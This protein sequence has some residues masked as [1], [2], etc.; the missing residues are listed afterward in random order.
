MK[1]LSLLSL[2][3]APAIAHISQG[4]TQHGLI[5]YGIRMYDPPCAFAC[6]DV[7]TGWMLH[8]GDAGTGGQ[9]HHADMEMETPSPLC[10]ATNDPFLQTLAWC[11][12]THCQSETMSKL[13]GWWEHYLVGRQP[14]QP[15]PKI[16]YQRALANVDEP[17][18]TIISE[19]DYLNTTSLVDEDSWLAKLN[20]DGGY[21]ITEKRSNTYG[22]VLLISCSVIPTVFSLFRFLPLPQSF[23]SK[24]Y[25]YFIDPPA[26][27]HSH[28][29][30]VFG[31]GIVPTR[32]QALFIAYIWIINILLSA[33]GYHIT[34]PNSWYGHKPE[35]VTAYFGNRVGVLSFANLGLTVLYSSRNNILLYLTNWSHSTFLLVH[36]W[37]AFICTLQ[38]C[39]H[40]AVWLQIYLAQG[41]EAHA[42]Q[43][44]L[45]YWIW[46]IVATMALVILLPLSILPIRQKMYELFLASHVVIAILSMIG[47][48]LHIYYRFTWQ[49]GYETWVY[50]A[51]VIWGFDRFFARP[52][53]VLR[54]G[55]KRAYVTV[56][57]EDYLKVDIPGVQASG[58]A[59]LYFPGL[60][61]RV[62]E[63]HPFSVAAVSGQGLS[64]ALSFER[65]GSKSDAPSEELDKEGNVVKSHNIVQPT[66]GAGIT[67]FVRRHGG[68][69][70]QLERVASST[71]G[72]LVL[73]ESSYGPEQMS[74]IPSPVAKP[75]LEYPNVIFFAGGVGITAVLPLL[76][77][78]NSL[79]S[80]LGKAKL[81]WGVRTES[82]VESVEKMLGQQGTR[83][84]GQSN[85]ANIEVNVSVGERFDVRRV[86][87]TELN[88]STGGTT[89]VVC[90][91]AGMSDDVRVAVSALA[92]HGAVLRL[93]EESFSW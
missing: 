72:T 9:S 35:E 53:R 92:R 3:A 54:N 58:Q 1:S 8:C 52:L 82:L 31:M 68:L 56:V 75:S 41:A 63:N 38:A 67:F 19:D 13:E 77:H 34:W 83:K 6:R 61:W 90:G 70:S 88:S 64:R 93:S 22:L 47:C 45:E 55:F 25:A 29:V 39:L 73:V 16:S 5:G 2:L 44:A 32:G 50:I 76:D 18:T 4:R 40:S 59:Y 33:V 15:S 79:C 11:I 7:V 57:D 66:R 24:F 17:P 14:G 69:T 20:G 87:E 80:P 62:W 60:T 48:L 36:R 84:N 23:V 30:P 71:S 26:F 85:W 65:S 51:F 43:A 12:S 42:E 78:A 46:G 81:F 49:W 86:L 74:I 21:D 10:Y 91:P 27:G 37:I 28:S 89:V